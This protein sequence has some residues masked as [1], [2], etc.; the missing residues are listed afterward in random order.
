MRLAINAIH[1]VN[2]LKENN[3]DHPINEERSFEKIQ[4]PAKIK[5]FN[6]LGIEGNFLDLINT[7]YENSIANI[8]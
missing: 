3:T 5:T 6:K 7:K 4:H 1:H 8:I 2:K